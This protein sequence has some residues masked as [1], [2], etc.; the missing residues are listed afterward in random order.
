MK[1]FIIL[2]ILISSTLVFG[3][4]NFTEADVQETVER[5]LAFEKWTKDEYDPQL[6]KAKRALNLKKIDSLKAE[7]IKRSRECYSLRDKDFELNK[8]VRKQLRKEWS[9]RKNDGLYISWLRF[10]NRIISYKESYIS[11]YYSMKNPIEK[12]LVALFPLIYLLTLMLC[13]NKILNML[14]RFSD[15]LSMDPKT[16]NSIRKNLKREWRE[17]MMM[18]RSIE[19]IILETALILIM[20]KNLLKKLKAIFKIPFRILSE[21]INRSPIIS[22]ITVVFCIVLVLSTPLF[23][24]VI[25][26]TFAALLVMVE[27]TKLGL[28]KGDARKK[29]VIL[30][31]TLS[32][33]IGKK[34]Q[35]INEAEARER[36][37]AKKSKLQKEKEKLQKRLQEIKE[38]EEQQQTATV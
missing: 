24:W 27:I 17:T 7:R 10:R 19:K 21:M 13:I 18:V 38:I 20:P 6:K 16:K 1:L 30:K 29:G 5:C 14:R 15:G 22:I 4:I 3:K 12:A 34:L 37:E 2:T 32:E 11:F 33:S 8:T 28:I 31:E 35:D 36:E 23:F 26:V 9:K 25:I